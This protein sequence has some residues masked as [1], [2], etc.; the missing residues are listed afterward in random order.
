MKKTIFLLAFVAV[1]FAAFSQIVPPNQGG[2]FFGRVTYRPTYWDDSQV[3][4]LAIVGGSTAPGLINFAGSSDVKVYGFDGGSRDE[5]AHFSI[6]LSHAYKEGTDLEPHL[7]WCETAAPTSASDTN[8]VW[9][10]TY[11]IQNVD[12][13]FSAPTTLY[14]TN[15]ITGTNWTHLIAGFDPDIDG[16]D[17]KISSVLVGSVKRIASNGS[18]TYDKDAALLSLDF[19]YQTDAPGSRENLVK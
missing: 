9:S 14:A 18:D 6:Q 8:V 7:H 1:S 11:S 16:A 13:T 2:T 3:P 19:H 17:L 4:G 12:G 5:E 10:M 15:S